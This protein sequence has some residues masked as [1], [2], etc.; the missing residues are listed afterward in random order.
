[1]TTE[2]DELTRLAFEIADEAA[3]SDIEVL[4]RSE[5]HFGE[6][7]GLWYDIAQGPFDDLKYCAI[8]RAVR[9]LEL[10]GEL[11]CHPDNPNVV[12]KRR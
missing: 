3:V 1:M 11:E 4:C 2:Q 9:Y 8:Y 5:F 7:Y 10:R 6:H 12:R